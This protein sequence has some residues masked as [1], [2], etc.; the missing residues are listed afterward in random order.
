M[1]GLGQATPAP[2]CS[3]VE[4]NPSNEHNSVSLFYAKE[5]NHGQQ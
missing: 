1:N 3:R 5:K 4:N 2:F